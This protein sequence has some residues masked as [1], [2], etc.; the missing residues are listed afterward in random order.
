MFSSRSISTKFAW[1]A[2]LFGA[3]GLSAQIDPN[4]VNWPTGTT[5]CVYAPATNTCVSPGGAP[6]APAVGVLTVNSYTQGPAG[7]LDIAVTPAAASELNVLTTASLNGRLAVNYLPGAYAAHIYQIVSAASITGSFSNVVQTGT[8]GNFVTGLYYNPDPHVELV[9]EPWSAAQGYGAID[10]ATLDQAQSLSSIV[11]SRQPSAGCS[12]DMR[13]RLD[14]V[15]GETRTS[16]ASALDQDKSCEGT[17]VWSQVL[18]YGSNTSSSSLASSANDASGGISA[19]VETVVREFSDH[20][21]GGGQSLGLALAYTS[22]RLSQSAASLTSTGNTLFVSL[23]GGLKAGGVAIDAQ[24]FYLDTQWSMKRSVAGYGVA[25]SSPNGQTAGGALQISYPLGATG[26]EPYAR[27][28]YASFD[29]RSTVETGPSIGAL[30]LAESS[31]STPSTLAEAG[32]KWTGAYSQSGGVKISP[33]LQIGVQQN[34]SANDR[35]AASSLALIPG[36]DFGAAATKPDQTSV[37]VG[38]TLK[39]RV[40]TRFDLFTSL[41]GRF[42]GN[43]TDGSIAFGGSYRF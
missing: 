36:T 13:A 37:V 1:L 31:T 18:A 9:V 6:G 20:R 28:S 12:G 40:D 17:A 41:N 42:S 10:T 14:S 7:T 38:G 35:T 23:Y 21:F 11:S 19:G 32:L 29:R 24:A 34:L 2:L 25:S 3:A 26:F 8:P 39:A 33:A 30:A 43:Q 22:N 16:G 4:Q 27:V 5:G 15:N